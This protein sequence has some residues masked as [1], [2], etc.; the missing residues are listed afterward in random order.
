MNKSVDKLYYVLICT[1]LFLATLAVYLPVRNHQFVHYDDDTYVTNN[2]HVLSGLTIENIKWAFTT[3]HGSNFHPVTW[4][5][6]QLDCTIFGENSGPHH[7]VNVFWH[8]ANTILLFVLLQRMTKRIWPSA[9]VAALFALHPLH[10]ES[11]AWVAERKDVLSTFFWLLTMLAYAHYTERPKPAR[12]LLTLLV[13]IIGLMTKPMLVTLPFCLLLLDYW[14]LNRIGVNGPVDLRTTSRP[15]TL[16]CQLLSI[17]LLFEKIPF[18][19]LS[20]VSSVITFIVQQRTGAVPSFASLGW[21]SRL[22]NAV[23][24]CLAY[25]AKM[26]WPV[27][28]AV[29]YPHPAGGIPVARAVIFAAL[30]LLMTFFLLYHARR[31]RYLAFGWLWYLG[32]LVPV[33]GIVQVGVQAMADRYTYIPLIGIFIIIAWGCADLIKNVPAGKYI[34]AVAASACLIACGITTR[35]QLGYW[36]DGFSLFDHTL[37]VTKNNYVIQNNYATVLNNLD[38]PAEAVE[39]FKEALRFLPDSFEVHNNYGNALKKLGRTDQAVKHFRL[40]LKL[41]PDA[42]LTHYNLALALVAKGQYDEA[43]EHYKSYLGPEP[44]DNARFDLARRLNAEGKLEEAIAQYRKVLK[45]AP[46]HVEA[47]SNLG[48]AFAKKEQYQKALE[49]YEKALA[50]DG[51]DIITHGRLALALAPLGRIDEAI[52]QCRIVLKVLPDDVE[53]HTNLGILLQHQGKLDEAITCYRR[54]LKIDPNFQ[55]ARDHLTAALTQK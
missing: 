50:V 31:Y 33:I 48:H 40:A 26:F 7:L 1:V 30:L 45:F 44:Q 53:M 55:K 5:S 24:S 35:I 47:L 21:E 19:A 13:F 2:P 8:I 28:L 10:V 51:N 22:S 20:A 37:A 54:A 17:R 12:Y 4:L 49:Y 23:V 18:L 9:F 27:R 15:P 6:H 3:G 52:K 46:D 25:I 34:L 38:R 42:K 43:I 32:T 16:S 29:L 14:P 39:H 36:K 41:N 11:V